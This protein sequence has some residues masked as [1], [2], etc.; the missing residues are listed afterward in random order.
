MNNIDKIKNWLAALKLIAPVS[1]SVWKGYQN[2]ANIHGYTEAV[3]KAG[4]SLRNGLC[5]NATIRGEKDIYYN[6][7]ITREGRV[8]VRASEEKSM[9]VAFH[10]IAEFNIAEADSP[11]VL[12]KLLTEAECWKD[13]NAVYPHLESV[14]EKI[15]CELNN[16]VD[17]LGNCM[18]NSRKIVLSK[19]KSCDT[20]S[21]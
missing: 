7:Y 18:P 3:M 16:L 19:T 13:F 1:E 21:A 17:F 5:V 15:A 2:Y 14:L 8:V 9:F 4:V 11:E 6:M 12:E 10:N 20:L